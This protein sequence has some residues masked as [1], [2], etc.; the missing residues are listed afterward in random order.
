MLPNFPGL[1]AAQRRRDGGK[2]RIDH[3][4]WPV[5]ERALRR[6][7]PHGVDHASA[8]SGDLLTHIGIDDVTFAPEAEVK[9]WELGVSRHADQ[10]DPLAGLNRLP[11]F[12]RDASVS[13]MAI[14][15]FPAASVVDDNAVAALCSFDLRVADFIGESVGDP[16]TDAADK[17]GCG[18]KS[19]NAL[20]HIR[21][22]SNPEIDAFVI[23][24]REN[25][26]CKILSA[27]PRIDI[28]VVLNETGRAKRTI[29]GEFQNGIVSRL[30]V[31]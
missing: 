14:L 2:T 16:V 23:V 28:H 21:K 22:I 18:R 7:A 30:A 25:A 5:C 11:L 9:M 4:A 26:A 12:D 19:K 20:C 29:D 6:R 1:D 24:V 8:R 27:G 10:S 3:A 15:C 13:E 17:T 31:C